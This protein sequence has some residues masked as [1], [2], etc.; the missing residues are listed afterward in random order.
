VKLVWR[1]FRIVVVFFLV[2]GS[3][4]VFFSVLSSRSSFPAGVIPVR[5]VIGKIVSML[6]FWGTYCAVGFLLLRRESWFVDRLGER[7]SVVILASLLC[8][9]G[10]VGGLLFRQTDPGVTYIDSR[11]QLRG[12][13]FS[14]LKIDTAYSHP[15][16][17]RTSITLLE[18]RLLLSM[19][20]FLAGGITLSFL[21]RSRPMMFGESNRLALILCM[22]LLIL[23]GTTAHLLVQLAQSST[24]TGLIECQQRYSAV[25]DEREYWETKEDLDNLMIVVEKNEEYNWG[26]KYIACVERLNR[27][28]QR[29]DELEQEAYRWRQLYETLAWK[30]NETDCA[31]M[32]ATITADRDKYKSMWQQ[33]RQSRDE[34]ESKYW[35]MKQERDRWIARYEQNCTDT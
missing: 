17:P 25:K 4:G 19:V 5:I 26:A 29:M 27:T 22:V 32:L 20:F 10:V 2:L 35:E 12:F 13:P 30:L 15:V 24:R 9:L 11:H 1:G 7:G 8:V 34:W 28:R 31:S 21:G 6:L 16:G 18:N 33:M 14:W 23:V 3:V